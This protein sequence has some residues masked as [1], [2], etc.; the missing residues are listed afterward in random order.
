MSDQCA[1]CKRGLD[2]PDLNYSEMGDVKRY[3]TVTAE[4]GS[5]C[6]VSL[7]FLVCKDC[8]AFL[9]E[10]YVENPLPQGISKRKKP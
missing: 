1:V 3:C 6:K 5:D 8:V 7:R 10:G 4:C 2:F 9:A